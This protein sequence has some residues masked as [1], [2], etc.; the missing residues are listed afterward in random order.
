MAPYFE[1][2]AAKKKQWDAFGGPQA[3]Q[4]AYQKAVKEW[5]ALRDEAKKKKARPPRRPNAGTYQD[6]R[7]QRHPAGMYNGM[8]HPIR[9]FQ[10]RGILFYQG[11]NNSFG[12]SWKPF[13]QTFPLVISQWR[14]TSVRCRSESFKSPAGATGAR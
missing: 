9:Q 6:P 8:I 2:Y 10:F 13:P 4:R 14:E 12:E 3:A 5:E 1:Q 7:Q 11:E